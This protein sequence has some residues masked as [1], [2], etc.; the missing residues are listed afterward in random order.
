MGVKSL[1]LPSG[2]GLIEVRGALLSD[3][4][5][6]GLRKAVTGFIER[7]E[8]KLLI[9]FNGVTF[10]N[11]SAIGVMVSAHTSYSKRSWELTFCGINKNVHLVLAIT[12]LNKVFSIHGSREEA[13]KAFS[14][15]PG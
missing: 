6:S 3:D 5:L 10:I 9:D 8:R 4:E 14:S 2:I 11:S 7:G 13:L 1:T 15:S 12:N